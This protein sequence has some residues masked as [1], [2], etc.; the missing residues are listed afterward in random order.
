MFSS[1]SLCSKNRSLAAAAAAD[2][3]CFRGSRAHFTKSEIATKLG[4]LLGELR[5][6]SRVRSCRRRP[7][8][9]MDACTALSPEIS[10]RPLLK[11]V[12]LA[13]QLFQGRVMQHVFFSLSAPHSTTQYCTGYVRNRL[14]TGKRTPGVPCPAAVGAGSSRNN[15]NNNHNKRADKRTTHP[16]THPLSVLVFCAG[17]TMISG[18]LLAQG[19][20]KKAAEESLARVFPSS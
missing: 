11:S 19:G 1:A 14:L 15:N 17:M 12:Q 13:L 4:E 3:R 5:A 6:A 8:C 20:G 16:P 18:P 2:V 7:S 10:S 9:E